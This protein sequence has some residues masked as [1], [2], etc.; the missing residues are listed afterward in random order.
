MI[1][2]NTLLKNIALKVCYVCHEPVFLE[3]KVAKKKIDDVE[4]TRHLWHRIPNSGKYFY[5]LDEAKSFLE[6]IIASEK[7]SKGSYV[8]AESR[9]ILEDIER[10]LKIEG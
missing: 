4:R 5:D 1:T 10:L 2:M 6:K 8:L 3:D 9:D 7:Y